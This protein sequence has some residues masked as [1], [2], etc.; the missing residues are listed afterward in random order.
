MYSQSGLQTF[1]T[2]EDEASQEMP[3]ELQQ[4]HFPESRRQWNEQRDGLGE[5]PRV[6]RNW[7]ARWFFRSQESG[8]GPGMACSVAILEGHQ[9]MGW[10]QDA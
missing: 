5:L 8:F 2:S 4:L 6:E 7:V 10:T 1:K 9:S 3:P